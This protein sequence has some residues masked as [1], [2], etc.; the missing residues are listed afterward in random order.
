MVVRC[1]HMM[2]LTLREEHGVS[3]AYVM[4][5]TKLLETI[6]TN[7]LCHLPLINAVLECYVII[8]RPSCCPSKREINLVSVV[9]DINKI[10]AQ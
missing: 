5:Y 1:F 9:E 4:M 2:M 6:P 10:G 8:R 3:H 7:C